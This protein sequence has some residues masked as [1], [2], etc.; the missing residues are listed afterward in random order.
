MYL[1]LYEITALW[2]ELKFSY[3]VVKT[4]FSSPQNV[5]LMFLAWGHEHTVRPITEWFGEE[6]VNDIFTI[7]ELGS[8]FICACISVYHVKH[9]HL[10]EFQMLSGIVMKPGSHCYGNLSWVGG[11]H[12][13][14]PKSS[15][16][17]FNVCLHALCD[18]CPFFIKLSKLQI[19]IMFK[20]TCIFLA[21]QIRYKSTSMF[22]YIHHP[23][24]SYAY[25]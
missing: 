4:D 10:I 19:F 23:C 22:K 18:F 11:L 15:L 12:G 17:H 5:C 14:S 13:V 2:V 16:W 24:I 1:G 3:G 25:I 8:V 7:I 6:S 9:L 21:I 20:P